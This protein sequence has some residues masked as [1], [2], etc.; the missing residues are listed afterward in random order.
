MARDIRDI[1]EIKDQY[2]QHIH[3]TAPDMDK[4]WNRIESEIDKKENVSAQQPNITY[5]RTNVKQ[6]NV[7]KSIFTAMT[8]AAAAIVIAVGAVHMSENLRTGKENSAADFDGSNNRTNSSESIKIDPDEILNYSSLELSSTSTAAYKEDYTAY[9][10]EYFVEKNVLE[11]T[12][13]FADV[14]VLK[15]DLT[16]SGGNYTLRV[17]E[18]YSKDGHDTQTGS[19]TVKSSTPYIMQEN[20]EYFI[21]L[22]KESGKYYLVFENAPQIE[23]TLDGGAVFQNGWNSLDENSCSVNKEELGKN[24]FYYDR[25]RYCPQ[26]DLTELIESWKNT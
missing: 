24:D 25:M 16:A 22:K 6:A 12:D 26:E 9:G 17:N 20:R 3:D 19:F 21:P 2:K 18:L 8:A 14:T 1:K 15:A 10:D 23:I 5:S 11:Q 4:L 7:K 13:C